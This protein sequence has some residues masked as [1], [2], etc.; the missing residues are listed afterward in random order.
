[1]LLYARRAV[2]SGFAIQPTLNAS[3]SQF[4][5][6]MKL[7][8]VRSAGFSGTLPSPPRNSLR[9]CS[10]AIA[11]SPRR[12]PLRI[13]RPRP[14]PL[15]LIAA[16]PRAQSSWHAQ[17]I[18]LRPKTLPILLFDSILRELAGS[19]LR[20]DHNTLAVRAANPS[21]KFQ[22]E[23]VGRTRRRRTPRLR[24]RRLQQP[25]LIRK[26]IHRHHPSR[27][28]RPDSVDLEDR[29]RFRQREVR[30]FLGH[31]PIGAE[32]H[33]FERLRVIPLAH[34]DRPASFHH[35]DVLVFG[36]SVRHD[37]VSR[38]GMNPKHVKRSGFRR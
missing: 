28:K 37:D 31:Q 25:A 2:M 17:F 8:S 14:L 10:I 32:L 4:P 7:P 12:Q 18:A 24:S 35:H 11:R 33:W 16:T 36:M 19:A 29:L 6:T 9:R 3:P 30:H 27:R 1:M 5:F 20:R 34:A 38:L 21:A 23:A 22:G 15:T 26:L 13:L